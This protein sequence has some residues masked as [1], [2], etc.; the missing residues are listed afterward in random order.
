MSGPPF[1][2]ECLDVNRSVLERGRAKAVKAGVADHI[3]IAPVDLN[4][5]QPTLR[6][7]AVIANQSLHHIVALESLFDGVAG[8]LAPHGLFIVSDMI[9][10][11][12]TSAG[13]RR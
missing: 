9:A 8:A 12:A 2:I 6:Y 11:T 4:R 1:A 3:A 7:D 13:R 5:W 10:A